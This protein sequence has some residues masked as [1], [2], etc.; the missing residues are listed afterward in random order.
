[1]LFAANLAIG[2]ASTLIKRG[3]QR[4]QLKLQQRQATNQ[5]V[6]N[7]K[8]TNLQNHQAAQSAFG[9]RHALTIQGK[10][11]TGA[12]KVQA[13]DSGLE[14]NSIKEGANQQLID[15]S[16]ADAG[17][18]HELNGRLAQSRRA[19]TMQEQDLKRQFKQ[20]QPDS[21]LAD[22]VGVVTSSLPLWGK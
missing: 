12:Y 1:M 16:L 9:Q 2:L 15:L 11:A 20:M 21:F 14:G 7:R 10:H 8:G 6:D 3:S 17:V 5:L 18:T 22:I 13:A 19:L 4:R